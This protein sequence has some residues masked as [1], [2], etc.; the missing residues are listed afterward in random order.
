MLRMIA[1]TPV[2]E[3]DTAEKEVNEFLPADLMYEKNT[4][5]DKCTFILGGK[6]TVIAGN[7][8]FRSDVSSWS[9]LAS[10]A[11]RDKD[12]KTD[13]SAYVSSGPCRCLQFSRDIFDA[14]LA[15]SELERLP[16][17]DYNTATGSQSQIHDLKSE[18]SEVGSSHNVSV[19]MDMNATEHTS[20]VGKGT[21]NN[22]DVVKQ[23]GELLKK[24][25][26][27]T[28]VVDSSR[29]SSAI[30]SAV[31]MGADDSFDV[32]NGEGEADSS[33]EE[34]SPSKTD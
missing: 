31:M 22:G 6:V 15:A 9:L 28:N 7:D 26:S 16:P 33:R 12:Y 4:P 24:L 3:L 17:P 25:L 21:N 34:V 19:S 29:P 23:R 32:S 13:F 18:P 14:A 30:A 1:A 2:K 5:S 10:A 11:L 27:T 20:S 8:N